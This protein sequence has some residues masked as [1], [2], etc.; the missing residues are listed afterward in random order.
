ML[1][2]EEV[3]EAGPGLRALG[4]KPHDVILRSHYS[5][6]HED[7]PA[8]TPILS[9]WRRAP[10]PDGTKAEDSSPVRHDVGAGAR[11]AVGW[12]GRR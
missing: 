10:Q 8:L 2:L 4:R 12:E 3:V 11:S 7:H 6:M 9:F 1:L 5:W